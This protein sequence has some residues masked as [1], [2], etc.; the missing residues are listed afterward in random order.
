MCGGWRVLVRLH[1]QYRSVLV[2]LPTLLSVLLQHRLHVLH[3]GRGLGTLGWFVGL[4]RVHTT[5]LGGIRSGRSSLLLCQRRGSCCR[6]CFVSCL[7]VLRRCEHWL[8]SR[9]GSRG[10]QGGCTPVRLSRG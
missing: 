1:L 2:H 9:D 6:T 8:S 5:G 10:L 3:C 4:C 7:L